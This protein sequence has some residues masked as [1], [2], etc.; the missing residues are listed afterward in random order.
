VRALLRR[1]ADA[2]MTDEAGLTALDYA[3]RKLMRLMGRERSIPPLA[4]PFE[5]GGLPSPRSPSLDENDQLRLGAC[6]Q[7]EIDR[8]REELGPEGGEFVRVYWQER[9]RAARR[10]FDDPR[11]VEAIVEILEAAARGDG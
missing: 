5:G 2:G 6:E 3:Q 9:L 7:A 8:M 1:G 10:V 11:E 4:P